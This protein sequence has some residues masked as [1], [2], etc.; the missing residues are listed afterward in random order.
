MQRNG[1][2]VNKSRRGVG[3]APAA[4]VV[5]GNSKTTGLA[6]PSTARTEGQV[7]WLRMSE[8]IPLR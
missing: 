5:L 1:L 6:G 4:M 2:F 8:I 3:R 7:P